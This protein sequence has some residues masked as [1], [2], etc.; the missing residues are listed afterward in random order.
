MPYRYSTDD[1]DAS[2]IYDETPSK[3][4][5]SFYS[6]MK[7]TTK[8]LKP[9]HDQLVLGVLDRVNVNLVSEKIDRDHSGFFSRFRCESSLPL[10]TLSI[11]LLLQ[12]TFS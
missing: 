3:E 10:L 2:T 5:H 8:N 12:L 6:S 1:S 9:S 7:K 11:L 4:A